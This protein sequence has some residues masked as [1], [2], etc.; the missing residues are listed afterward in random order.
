MPI[1]KPRVLLVEDEPTL[2]Q[3][4]ADALRF[5]GYECDIA[6]DGEQG[7]AMARRGSYDVMLLDL[8]LPILSGFEVM[9]ALR[10]EGSRVPTIMLTAKGAEDDKVRGL[11]LGADDYVTKPFA[12]RELMA[13]VGAQLRRTRRERGDGET[14]EIDG[15]RFDLGR[16]TGFRGEEEIVLTPR[17]GEIL[18]YLR[19]HQGN[20]VTRDEFLLEVW[21][22]PTASVETRTVDNTLAALRKKIE[23]NPAD[24]QIIKTVRGKGYRWGA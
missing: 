5:Q 24:P 12:I 7:L 16:L 9:E 6:S 18:S 10:G 4:L 1:E 17:E 8:M 3:G 23:T 19:A 21:K 11:E 2:A 20:V 22:Y 13:R 14:F 15:V